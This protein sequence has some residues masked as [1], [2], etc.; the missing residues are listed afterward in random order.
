MGS[1]KFKFFGDSL[2]VIKW[3]RKEAQIKNFTLQPLYD[4]IQ[5][6]MTTFSHISLSHIYRDM[7]NIVMA[8]QKMDWDWNMVPG[9]LPFYRMVTPTVTSTYCKNSDVL[10]AALWTKLSILSQNRGNL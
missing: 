3:I 10:F 7:N 1:N 2:L 8:F 5:M 9:L 4:D 6:Q